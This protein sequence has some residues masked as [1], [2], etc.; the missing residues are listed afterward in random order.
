[1]CSAVLNFLS[2]SVIV[3]QSSSVSSTNNP[4]V[5]THRLLRPKIT[6][7]V[8]FKLLFCQFNSTQPNLPYCKV[9]FWL[10]NFFFRDKKCQFSL[11]SVPHSLLQHFW[12]TR[13]LLYENHFVHTLEYLITVHM[14]DL[15]KRSHS[16]HILSIQIDTKSLELFNSLTTSN[17]PSLQAIWIW[18][19]HYVR[20]IDA[21][22]L[23][24]TLE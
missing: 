11:I 19:F 23:L 17:C 1:M 14:Y 20:L 16:I 24:D 13:Q 12:I 7:K 3:W 5:M 18:V 10:V 2:V 9:F 6:A 4:H 15:I 22:R 8:K 21:V